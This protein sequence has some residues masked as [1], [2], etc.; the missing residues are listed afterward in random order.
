MKASRGL[1]LK[2]SAIRFVNRHYRNVK[3]ALL[4]HHP[5]VI[6]GLFFRLLSLMDGLLAQR[7]LNPLEKQG[8]CSGSSATSSPT[9]R[10]TT[11]NMVRGHGPSL[12]DGSPE[13]GFGIHLILQKA[14]P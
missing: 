4:T 6:T 2:Y 11:E 8:T 9:S 10:V 12:K 5:P 13:H 1:P 7:K 3:T 14:S